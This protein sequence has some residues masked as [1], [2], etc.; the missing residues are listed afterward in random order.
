M[1]NMPG[2]APWLLKELSLGHASRPNAP[3]ASSPILPDGWPPRRCHRARPFAA[4]LGLAF[5]VGTGVACADFES[6]ADAYRRQDYVT[7]YAQFEPQAHAGDPRAQTV[8]ALMYKYGESVKP[9]YATA[10]S[11]Y[12]RAANQGYAPA[13][14]S[15]GLMLAEGQGIRA[16]RDQGLAW[17]RKAADNGYERAR[18]EL[19]RLNQSPDRSNDEIKEWSQAW[20]FSLPNS[21]RYGNA[22]STTARVSS[23]A[24]FTQGQG[25]YKV[26]LGAMSTRRAA[27][28]LWESMAPRQPG[29]FEGLEPT[30]LRSEGDRTIYR[31]QAGPFPSLTK[32][33]QFCTEVVSAAGCMPLRSGR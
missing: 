7:A 23:A 18:D 30:Y 28:A 11:W 10:F 21:I 12:Q 22:S 4:F 3:A 16:D 15:V 25:R 26:Q 13:Q 6:A 29:L 8:I 2:P 20:D 5:L 27:E 9:N 24:G 32:A 31:L 33:R 14:F 17:L 19:A 1:Q